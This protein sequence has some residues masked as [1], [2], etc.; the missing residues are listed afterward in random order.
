MIVSQLL[1]SL[2]SRINKGGMEGSKVSSEYLTPHL[3][4]TLYPVD[5]AK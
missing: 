1:L 4:P 3:Q 2:L 5:R